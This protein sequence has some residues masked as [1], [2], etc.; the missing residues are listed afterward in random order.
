MLSN[1]STHS[2]VEL[3][4]RL[5]L[6][7][8][9]VNSIFI[10]IFL[11]FIAH[12]FGIKRSYMYGKNK[13]KASGEQLHRHAAYTS[14]KCP[15]LRGTQESVHCPLPY[16]DRWTAEADEWVKVKRRKTKPFSCRMMECDISTRMPRTPKPKRCRACSSYQWRHARGGTWKPARRGEGRA[17]NA[18]SS[19]PTRNK[20]SESNG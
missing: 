16:G 5:H 3:G 8:L 17:L 9:S 12:W 10:V 14:H 13:P 2:S 18:I 7:N 4:H 15:V 11:S 19:V 1:I 6:V 20:P